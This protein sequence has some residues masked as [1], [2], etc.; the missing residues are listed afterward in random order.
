MKTLLLIINPFS[1]QKKANKYLPEI[2]QMF[3][4][5]G[6][7]TVVHVTAGHGDA[8]QTVIRQGAGKDLIVCCGGDGTMNETVTGLPRFDAINPH[9]PPRHNRPASRY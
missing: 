5:A 1:G 2:I 8:T 6:Y 7:E 9:L 4:Q 3:N